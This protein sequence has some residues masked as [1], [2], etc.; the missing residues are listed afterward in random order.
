[1]KRPFVIFTLDKTTFALPALNVVQIEMPGQ[2]T[3]VPNTADFISGIINLRGEI[4]PVV[5]MRRRFGLPPQEINL[6]S[7]IIVTRFENRI[8]GLLVDNARE[9]VNLEDEQILLPA[10]SMRGPGTDYLEGICPQEQRLILILSLEKL[11]SQDEN[12]AI[13]EAAAAA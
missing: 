10:E 4:I 8:V 11:F 2:I 9:F 6:R 5:D 7:R 13:A 3:P 1:M 12:Q